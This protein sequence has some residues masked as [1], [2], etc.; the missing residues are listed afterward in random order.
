M[1]ITLHIGAHKTAST[2]I[3]RALMR[4]EARLLESGIRYLRRKDVVKSP[5]Q[6]ALNSILDEQGDPE[7]LAAGRRYLQKM[8][9]ESQGCDLLISNENMFGRL[10]LADFYRQI[11]AQLTYLRG[12]VGADCG[13]KI[14]L[15]TRRQAD[16]VES[17]YM[18]YVH[19]GKA[20]SFSRFLGDGLPLHLSWLRVVE[21][22]V[23]VVGPG[24]V[25]VKPF[26]VIKEQGSR[27]FYLD[28]LQSIGFRAIETISFD[29]SL[30][31]QRDGNRS[32]SEVAMEI[33]Q[34][35]NPLLQSASDKRKLRAFLQVNFSTATHPRARLL[36]DEQRLALFDR[37]R[38]SNEKLFARFM[39]NQD[40]HRMGYC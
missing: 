12:V 7:L 6:V 40:G 33:A 39:P 20:L 18:Q 19:L 37:Y 34:R 36:S 22:A 11:E 21:D 29:E 28:F 31:L 9:S 16:Y 5:L 17:V 15:Y 32:Y 26:E 10:G 27:Q 8:I 25:T 13:I 38:D 2:L 3:R 23:R 24:N 30:A 35:V 14:L 1:T 4:D